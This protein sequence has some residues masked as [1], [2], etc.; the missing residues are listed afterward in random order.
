MGA[1]RGTEDCTCGAI[2]MLILVSTRGWGNCGTRMSLSRALNRSI[3]CCWMV[4]WTLFPSASGDVR[5]F[6]YLENGHKSFVDLRTQGFWNGRR[7]CQ[8]ECDITRTW[9]QCG[10]FSSPSISVRALR[11]FR[12]FGHVVQDRNYAP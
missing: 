9:F 8:C 11:S 5:Y 1:L 3:S 12:Q 2:H 10:P 7:S 4:A 6:K